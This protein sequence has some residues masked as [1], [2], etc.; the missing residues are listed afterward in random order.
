MNREHKM[1]EED[2]GGGRRSNLFI[3]VIFIAPPTIFNQN[4][5]ND[6]IL[7]ASKVRKYLKKVI[8][9]V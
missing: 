9:A 7:Q 4:N 3:T 1:K 6:G 2:G 5:R 8:T